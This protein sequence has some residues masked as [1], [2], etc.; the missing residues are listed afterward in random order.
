MELSAFDT[1]I[2]APADG[3]P[4]EQ[5][6]AGADAY[7]VQLLPR[8]VS[9]ACEADGTVKD[10][11][12][13]LVTPS[14]FKGHTAVS[15]QISFGTLPT[16]VTAR[17]SVNSTTRA[18]EIYVA[19][20]FAAWKNDAGTVVYTTKQYPNVNVGDA[21][22]NASLVQIGTVD[23]K[24]TVFIKMRDGV[25]YSGYVAGIKGTLTD[26]VNIPVT[27]RESATG[28]S[29]TDYIQLVPNKQGEKGVKGDDGL[30]AIPVPAGEY[31]SSKTYTAT[32]FVAP[33]VLCEGKYYILNKTGSFKNINPK[34]DYET[35]GTN[36]T[37]L[38]L[39]NVQYVFTEILMANLALLGKAVFY[40]NYMFSQY[41]KRGDTVI[42]TAGNYSAP[43]EAGGDFTPNILIDFL[44]G[45]FRCLNA[46]I[47]GTVNADA[48]YFGNMSISG[49]KFE[50]K[51]GKIYFGV[52]NNSYTCISTTTT[53]LAR[54]ANLYL[55]NEEGGIGIFAHS[56]ATAL[57][58]AGATAIDADGKLNF[59][60]GSWQITFD[61]SGIAVYYTSS[62]TKY[63]VLNLYG[64]GFWV[65]AFGVRFGIAGSNTSG[66]FYFQ[67]LVNGVWTNVWNQT[68]TI[69]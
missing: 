27:L 66:N 2:P 40:G 46:E 15:F 29:K 12:E 34:T 53:E 56:T 14:L 24:G 11:G 5:G 39:E 36:A 55:S 58:L 38:Y 67:K 44:T 69:S 47:K 3:A 41:G 10:F 35:N 65:R 18:I 21:V 25:S 16:G 68:A 22:Y 62:G 49:D 63:Q 37:W 13:H 4:G 23:S 32:R 28:I 33:Y 61:G 31:S 1:L 6:P 45:F 19:A 43:T 50:A 9:V 51:N 42:N 26:S 60:Y 20:K 48:G 54:N 7:T 17:S 57:K 64:T 52:N 59:T 30:R 8:I